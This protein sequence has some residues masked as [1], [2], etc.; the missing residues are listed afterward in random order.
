[1]LMFNSSNAARKLWQILTV[2]IAVFLISLPLLSQT[3]QG[4]IQGRVF[5]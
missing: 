5:D 4:T 2:A 3:S 1:M